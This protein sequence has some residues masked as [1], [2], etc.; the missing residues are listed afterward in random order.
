MSRSA[1]PGSPIRFKCWRE[2]RGYMTTIHG[3]PIEHEIRLTGRRRPFL[4]RRVLGSRSTFFSREYT[5][6]CGH[7][8]WSNHRDLAWEVEGN[9]ELL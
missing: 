3:R 8:G 6:S 1:G 9:L 2:R 5:C 7:V 4:P